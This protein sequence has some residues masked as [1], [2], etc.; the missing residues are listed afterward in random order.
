[1]TLPLVYTIPLILLAL[2]LQLQL[3]V[4]KHEGYLGLRLNAADILLPFLGVLVIARLLLKKDHLPQWRVPGTY[5]WLV[6]LTIIMSMAVFNGH[7]TT[8]DWDRWAIINKYAGWYVL[9]AYFGLGGWIG[10]QPTQNWAQIT[11]YG[12]VIFWVAT[13]IVTMPFLISMDLRG[14]NSS[15]FISNTLA[16]FMGNRN[17]FA[18]LSISLLALMTAWQF[19]QSTSAIY[20]LNFLWA[21]VPFFYIYNASR[22]G[23]ISILFLL[24]FFC[25]LKFKFFWRHIF[26]PL[27]VGIFL[28]SLFFLSFP[29]QAVRVALG[30]MGNSSQLIDI[31]QL[32]AEN[33]TQK[34]NYV[35]DQVRISALEDAI[36]VWKKSPLIGAGLGTFRTYQTE[37]NG[38]S[39]D[40]IDCT[41]LWLLTETG[42]LGLFS[43]AGFFLIAL[44]KIFLKIRA[45][46]DMYGIYL[47]IFLMMM[48]F[49]IMSLVHELLYTRFLWFFMG[50][51]LA[52]PRD[53]R[54]ADIS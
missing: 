35:G 45:D 52:I 54:K 48:I 31:R 38:F 27:T 8:G 2:G 9:L 17:A 24:I 28:A 37:K 11:R 15:F 4:L 40:I 53:G 5:L 32:N 6:G 33:A 51:A 44:W 50:L 13:L 16:G 49:A 23:L 41:P 30:H 7:H 47:G 12:F 19:K 21:A 36:E 39:R 1:M 34:L 3:T 26:V 20:G 29:S 10:S 46:E 14:E 22:A 42:L 43:F 25:L 18:F